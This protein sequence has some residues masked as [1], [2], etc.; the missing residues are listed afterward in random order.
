MSEKQI[1]KQTGKKFIYRE[2][3]EFVKQFSCDYAKS[4]VLK[5]AYMQSL[6]EELELEG[7]SV[8]KLLAVRN[9]ENGWALVF[10]AVDGMTLAEAMEAAPEKEEEYL[11]LFVDLQSRI[12]KAGCRHMGRLKDKL[13][14]QISSLRDVLDATIRYEL[15]VRLENMKPHA[16]VVHGDFMPS[17]V[18]LGADGKIYV[19]DWAHAAIGNASADAALTYIQFYVTDEKLAERYLRSFCRT[20]D[21]ARQYVMKWLPI[22]AAAHMSKTDSADYETLKAMTEVVEF[23]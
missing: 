12:H 6:A 10:E 14:A 11:Q 16:K 17:N 19:T 15:H 3:S 5:E 4:A 13:N 20:N 18:I 21:I 9:Q 23:E 22:V 2:G 7:I 8:P 1:I